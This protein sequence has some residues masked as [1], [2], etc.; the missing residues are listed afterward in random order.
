LERFRLNGGNTITATGAQ[1]A[2]LAFDASMVVI[3]G[4]TNTLANSASA[5]SYAPTVSAARNSLVRLLDTQT[6]TNTNGGF[7]FGSYHNDSISQDS[8]FMTVTGELDIYN[9]SSIE[10]RDASIL[11]NAYVGM[12]S[13]LRLRDEDKGTAGND[14]NDA[15]LTGTVHSNSGVVDFKSTFTMNGDVQC[16]GDGASGSPTFAAEGFVGC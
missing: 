12:I 16:N 11:G 10:F 5:A 7:A 13:T 9:L 15:T 2:V 6:I 3:Q 14:G 4:S 1:N 8:G